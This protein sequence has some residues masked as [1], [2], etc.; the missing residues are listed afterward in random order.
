MI[1]E[2]KK[3]TP[4]ALTNTLDTISQKSRQKNGPPTQLVNS[5]SNHV[6]NINRNKIKN[7]SFDEDGKMLRETEAEQFDDTSRY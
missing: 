5:M 7:N 4:I 2:K 3:F 6:K 1:G